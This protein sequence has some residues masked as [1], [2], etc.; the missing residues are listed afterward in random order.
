MTDVTLTQPDDTGNCVNDRLTFSQDTKYQQVCGTTL[1][2]HC[3]L[4]RDEVKD[5]KCVYT[6]AFIFL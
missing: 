4:D 5:L 1:D 3:E 6:R 2:T